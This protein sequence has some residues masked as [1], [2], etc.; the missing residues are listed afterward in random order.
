[1]VNSLPKAGTNLLLKAL[2]GMPGTRRMR[3][4]L[5]GATAPPPRR[6][7][8]TLRIGID[9]PVEADV[10]AT[11]RLVRRTPPGGLLPAHVPYSE[12]L[13]EI[14]A[15]LDVRMALIVR[16]PR[17][18]AVS[19]V[20]YVLSRPHHF[21]HARIRALAP[22][23]RI[24][25]ALVGLAPDGSGRGLRSMV[26]RVDDASRWAAHPVCLLT[27]FEDLVGPQGGGSRGQQL[28]TL[29]RLAAHVGVQL[30]GDQL[31]GLADGLFGGTDTFRRGRVEAWR[32][33]FTPELATTADALLGDVL[34]DL[35]YPPSVGP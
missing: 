23:E 18:V 13:A 30:T 25:A 2:A 14:C 7:R 22:E 31:S 1:M 5:F 19:L 15:D 10:A 27:R 35:G 3:D 8:P 17:D 6:D 34:D 26:A 32:E 21:L 29:S 4:G 24:A 9:W 33:T 28:R 16:D 20:A 12:G 11:R